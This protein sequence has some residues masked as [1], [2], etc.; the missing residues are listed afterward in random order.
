MKYYFEPCFVNISNENE[1]LS[2]ILDTINSG[3][4]KTF[5]YL[6]SHSY[7]LANKNFKFNEAFN[8]ADYVIADGYS[9]VW[10][11]K[12]IY[13]KKIDKVVFTYSF[14]NKLK[15]VFEEQNARI[16]ILGG[17]E[18]LIQKSKNEFE[19]SY[20]KINVV[21]FHNG[22]FNKTA[23]SE[24]IIEM[25]N[26]SNPT[27]LIV[28]MGMPISEI[29]IQDNISK[30]ITNCIFSV[31][32]FLEFLTKSKKTAPRW[33][34]NSG[35]EWVHRLLQEPRRLFRRYLIANTFLIYK[36]INYSKQ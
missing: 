3:S 29:W 25:I 23:E 16:F 12:K 5:F 8:K 33:I 13:R 18:E 28:G 24:K 30:I 35:L 11:I 22:Y 9:I 36:L 2:S 32:G 6:N 26:S 20:P 15:T 4:K 17:S 34:Y 7:Y 21:G 19:R 31:G 14:F 10:A 1:Y 27:V